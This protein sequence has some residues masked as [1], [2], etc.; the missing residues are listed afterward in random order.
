MMT[1]PKHSLSLLFRQTRHIA[2][3]AVTL[4]EV[5][6]S[7]GVIL[8]GLLGLL[9]ILPL[10][11]RRSQDSI[12][13]NTGSAMSDN[14][15]TQL[16]SSRFL[17]RGEL[18]ALDGTVIGLTTAAP[19]L[20]PF[21]IDPLFCSSF[22]EAAN[23]ST[24]DPITVPPTLAGNGY[25]ESVF[26]HFNTNYSP[27]LDPSNSGSLTWA[28]PQP[29]LLRVGV[30][31]RIPSPLPPAGHTNFFLDAEQARTLVESNDD[32]PILRPRDTTLP[33]RYVTLQS[34]SASPL[35]YGKRIPSGEYTWIATVD[36][37]PGGVY[38]SIS[39]VVMRKRERDFVLPRTTTG[40]TEPSENTLGERV[41]FVSNAIGFQGGAGG[42]VELRGTAAVSPSI[43]SSDWIMLSRNIP[44]LPPTIPPNGFHRWYRVVSAE[45]EPVITGTPRVWIQQVMLDGP[46]WSFG[47]L[48]ATAGL[49]DN[50]IATIVRDVVSVSERVVLLSEL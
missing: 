14:V 1:H 13:F 46:D 37:L 28:T 22:E 32:L 18:L 49:P 24:T 4:V 34:S 8:I 10:A 38:A 48:P 40:A 16:L 36:P 33:S 42:V 20:V 31:R 7:I 43:R 39:V 23:V 2:R 12:S 21:V 25:A 47:V 19:P 11:G 50:T 15:L 6:F 26:P 30:R 35:A 5:I 9:S 45:P 44:T 17:S 29:R 27:L 41:A 3:R